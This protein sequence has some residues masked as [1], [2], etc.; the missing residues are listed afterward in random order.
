MSTV[1]SLSADVE[2][3]PSAPVSESGDGG[4]GRE[5]DDRPQVTVV[6]LL[7]FCV[8]HLAR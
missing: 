8:P 2:D 3:G 1:L 4:A 7:F 6:A 5:D